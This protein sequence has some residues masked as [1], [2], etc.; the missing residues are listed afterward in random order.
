MSGDNT[1]QSLV[2]ADVVFDFIFVI[3][4]VLH[5]YRPYVDPNT[6]QIVADLTAL[7]KRYLRSATFSVNVIA[8]TPILKTP[9]SPFL[10]KAAQEVVMTY[11][12]VLRMVRIL[13]LPSQFQ[14]LKRFRLQKGPVNESVFRMCIILFFTLLGMCILGC[15]YFGLSVTAASVGDVC[16]A[17]ED[18]VE[19][20]MTSEMWVA[21]DF[22]ITDVMD[23]RVCGLDDTGTSNRTTCNDCPQSLFFVRSIYFLMQTLF[24]IGYGDT[25]VPSKSA[26]E[27]ALACI[28]MVIGV[29]GYGL[30]IANMTSVLANLDVVSMRFRH[31][32]DAISRWMSFRCTPEAL[33]DHV[34]LCFMYYSRTQHGMLDGAL[35]D[36]LP[37]KLCNDLAA[38]HMDF[39]TKIPFFNRS[40]RSEAF[41]SRV[42]TAMI[43]RVYSPGSYILY[44]NEKQRELVIIKSGRAD[45]CVAESTE[46]VGSLLPGDYMGDYQLL[47]GTVN[48]VGLRASDDFVE[49][50]VLTHDNFAQQVMNHLDGSDMM[51]Q[52]LGGT[53]RDSNDQGAL[54][55]IERSKE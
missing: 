54:D 3:D 18:F 48:Q 42:A 23:P 44:Q 31:E 20:I 33:R 43:R 15:V 14:E 25:V 55:T 51:F 7:R 5:F 28:F 38:V 6:G 13:H 2:Y 30:I 17:S 47:F 45:I 50:L 34:N 39:I 49:V 24:T 10:G 36:D 26:V 19:N 9:L 40:L 21:E 27:M 8:C 35:F 12:N 29:F 1:P 53:F 16:A 4:T 52:A 32:M 37:P 11:F 41:L 22:V 46:A